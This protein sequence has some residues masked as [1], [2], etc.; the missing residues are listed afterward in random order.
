MW[1]QLTAHHA[2][3]REL[4]RQS[5]VLI[6]ANALTT[7]GSQP[8]KVT[9]PAHMITVSPDRNASVRILVDVQAG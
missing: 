9:A 3:L 7:T 5:H 8:V 4:A 1:G 2:D 6:G